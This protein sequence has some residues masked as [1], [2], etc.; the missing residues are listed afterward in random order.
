VRDLKRLA[1]I[2][3]PL[4]SVLLYLLG[5]NEA[6][7]Y[8]EASYQLI[9]TKK[10]VRELQKSLDINEE[11]LTEEIEK[12]RAHQIAFEHIRQP[13]DQLY[14]MTFFNTSDEVE[15]FVEGTFYNPAEKGLKTIDIS[16]DM[17]EEMKVYSKFFKELEY[18]IT[19]SHT[20]GE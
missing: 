18:E 6:D 4:L 19:Y 15:M 5:Q 2:V 9:E 1:I 17:E 14:Y 7:K 13:E 10:E 11:M 3:F 20:L 12:T 8:D 16:P